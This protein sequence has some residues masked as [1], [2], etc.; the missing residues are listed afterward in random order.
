[1]ALKATDEWLFFCLMN[2]L[3]CLV[4]PSSGPM[5]V[6]KGCWVNEK[7]F[8]YTLPRWRS[9]TI[10]ITADHAHTAS[11]MDLELPPRNNPSHSLHVSKNQESGS[12]YGLEGFQTHTTVFLLTMHL[13]KACTCS[14]IVL[15]CCS[16]FRINPLHNIFSVITK[17]ETIC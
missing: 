9:F 6:C 14:S 12:A 15:V 8:N 10:A 7:I 4:C 2:V 13:V 3:L 5:L 16:S 17:Y 11:L 1:M